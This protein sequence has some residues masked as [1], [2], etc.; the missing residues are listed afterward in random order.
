L[1]GLT[2]FPRLGRSLF[3]RR[4][5]TPIPI[6]LHLVGLRRSLVRLRK[7]G[8]AAEGTES[9][10]YFCEDEEELRDRLAKDPP[11][12]AEKVRGLHSPMTRLLIFIG[13]FVGGYL[14]WWVGDYFDLGLMGVFLV[15]SLGTAA[16]VYLGWKVGQGYFD[17]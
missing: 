3:Y 16:G 6:H 9:R 10:V 14:G 11:P 1:E 4:L 12:K 13:M 17:S 8:L 2:A 15:S 5:P 7:H